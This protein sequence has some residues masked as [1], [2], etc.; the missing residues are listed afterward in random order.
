[1]GAGG[2]SS[3]PSKA[4]SKPAN[5]YC[6][7]F[8]PLPS[9]RRAL[10]SDKVIVWKLMDEHGSHCVRLEHDIFTGRRLILVDDTVVYEKGRQLLD[11]GSS[12]AFN[13]G[14]H[15]KCVVS[16]IETGMTYGYAM[17]INEQTFA[18]FREQ[19]WK[20]AA[21][22]RVPKN[23]VLVSR[24]RT[25]SAANWSP[26]TK[27][28]AAAAAAD[29]VAASTIA[30][31][32]S[33]V[34]PA[35][36]SCLP[37]F[38]TVVV[39]SSPQLTVLL[40]GRPVELH[41]SFSAHDSTDP[42][43]STRH[44]FRIPLVQDDSDDD[45]DD[46]E[47][48]D[49]R[50]NGASA[51]AATAVAASSFAAASA[52]SSSSSSSSLMECEL[53]VWL[54]KDPELLPAGSVASHVPRDKKHGRTRY[55]LRINGAILAQAPSP[56]VSLHKSLHSQSGGG[57]NTTSGAGGQTA[58]SGISNGGGAAFEGCTGI[59]SHPSGPALKSRSSSSSVGGTSSPALDWRQLS[60][61]S[62]EL[63]MLPR[64]SSGGGANLLPSTP[65]PMLSDF[66]MLP[67]EAATAGGAAPK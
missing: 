49:E 45:D 44:T 38:H 33:P 34:A 22:W 41:S 20:Y 16:I 35:S 40:N 9:I 3:A 26:S 51:A 53:T 30:A 47:E 65:E 52:A 32:S 64:A 7:L 27:D 62:P 37:R 17:S 28:S 54:N 4:S 14:A 57:S 25:G 21:L 36:P 15:L 8:S 48:E 29:S 60:N 46:N 56:L 19:F 42:D 63:L 67:V 5:A 39:L 11:T 12:H 55:L 61:P 58:R 24:G 6:S 1:M 31:S 10:G 13:I 43:D 2:S 66:G 23:G 18:R 59:S 50:S